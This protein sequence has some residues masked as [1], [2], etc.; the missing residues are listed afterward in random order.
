M[1]TTTTVRP[2]GP[3][4]LDVL[5]DSVAGLFREDCGRHDPVRNVDWPAVEGL[6]YYRGVLDD[7]AVLLALAW[8]GDQPA[9]HL[10][11][12][13]ARPSSML[14]APIGVLESIRVAPAERGRGVGSLL[15]R[16]FTDWARG[17]GAVEFTVS[18]YAANDGA[19]R[20][21]QRH[22]FAPHSITLRAPA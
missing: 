7:P 18:A 3:G 2:A 14:R 20:F 17:H 15:V 16:E 21:Y 19:L 5:L 6:A 4:D 13:V 10:V 12:K 9:G 8:R 11:G 1:T 22:G